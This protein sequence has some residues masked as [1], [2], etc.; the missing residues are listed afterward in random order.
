MRFSGHLTTTV[1]PLSVTA[2]LLVLL[3]AGC[4]STSTRQ[5]ATPDP[6]QFQAAALESAGNYTGAAQ[7]YQQA[8]TKATGEQ[9]QA[10]LLKATDSLIRGDDILA[11]TAILDGLPPR[12]GSG[13][14]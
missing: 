7:L 9:Q 2:L 14:L 5:T 11:A 4:S 8:A 10:L 12:L 1:S 13:D 3:L 6:L